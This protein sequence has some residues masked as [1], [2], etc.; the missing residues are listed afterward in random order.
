MAFRVVAG[1]PPVLLFCSAVRLPPLEWK[2]E[3]NNF[4]VGCG[5][6]KD[7]VKRRKKK[8]SHRFRVVEGGGAM[9]SRS[10]ATSALCCVSDV[11]MEIIS[12]YSPT[13]MSLTL[14]EDEER[15]QRR[16]SGM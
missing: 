7:A 12:L 11:P 4:S 8:S 3:A 2:N 13:R 16:G 10:A 5:T 9:G 6:A 15:G 14:C 1:A